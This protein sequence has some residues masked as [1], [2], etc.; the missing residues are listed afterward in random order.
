MDSL[1]N[2]LTTQSDSQKVRTLIEIGTQYYLKQNDDTALNYYLNSL[3]LAESTKN[4]NATFAS[5]IAV[6]SFYDSH[7]KRDLALEFALRAKKIAEDQKDDRK[8]F[9]IYNIIGGIIYFNQGKFSQSLQYG[10]QMVK[11]AGKLTDNRKIAHTKM[12]LADVY[13]ELKLYDTAISLYEEAVRMWK[14]LRDTSNIR[15]SMNNIAIIFD[16]QDKY[17]TAIVYFLEAASIAEKQGFSSVQ[18]TYLKRAARNFS[19]LRNNEKA[20]Y[21]ADKAR[22]LLETENDKNEMAEVYELLANIYS[23]KADYKHAFEY[24]SKFKRIDDSLRFGVSNTNIDSLQAKYAGEKIDKEIE[25]L[26]KESSL[27][28]KLR[29]TFIGASVLAVIIALL[30]AAR[31]R[32]KKKSEMQLNS[33]NASLTSTLE[34]LRS[35][36][37]QL[38]QSEKMASLGELTAGIAH[39]IQNPMNFINNFSDVNNEL[40]EELKQQIPASTNGNNDDNHELLDQIAANNEKII[41]HGKRADAIVKSMLHHS[42]ANS[43]KKELTDINALADEYLK[44]AYHGLRA[45]DKSFN[46]KFNTSL[47]PAVEKIAIVPQE[48][49]RVL[50]NLINNAFY[51]VNQKQKEN[52]NGYEP[53][54][55]V[56]T[57]KLSDKIEIR[58]IDNGSGIPQTILDKIYQPFFTTKPTGQGTGL[59]LS[60]SYDI[61]TKGHGGSINVNTNEGDGTEFSI[62]IPTK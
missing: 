47:D 3:K 21:Y 48:I 17:D 25:F 33:K 29:N 15:T 53:T 10:L 13:R 36:Q 18:A 2:L 26:K 37:N 19:F 46:A 52:S 31:Y 40:I 5:L 35:T 30:I 34:T 62:I 12:Y 11:I 43:G 50:L 59:G 1:K 42:R 44:L 45:K 24:L 61:V 56:S 39:E 6:A 38:I 54:V 8:L 49:G 41:M 22:M 55:T 23:A 7:E 4:E 51:A 16:S 14:E 57:K 32:A 58:V 60:L 27:Q 9:D 28:T 20:L